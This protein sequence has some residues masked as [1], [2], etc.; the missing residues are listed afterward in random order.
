MMD[1]TDWTARKEGGVKET[2]HR[3]QSYTIY[4]YIHLRNV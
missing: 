1:K 3:Q 2:Y 4:M